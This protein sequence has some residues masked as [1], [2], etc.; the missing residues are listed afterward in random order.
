MGETE[1][2]QY[3]LIPPV[4][5][6]II[7][8]ADSNVIMFCNVYFKIIFYKTHNYHLC[9]ILSSH[10]YFSAV[11]IVAICYCCIITAAT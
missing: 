6:G 8:N 9:D 4:A 3:C 5:G 7:M 10:S 2:S 11:D 1:T